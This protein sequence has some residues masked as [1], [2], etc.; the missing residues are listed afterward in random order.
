LLEHGYGNSDSSGAILKTFFIGLNSSGA[1]A[2]QP[3]THWLASAMRV[4]QPLSTSI[5]FRFGIH[6]TSTWWRKT[7]HGV[8]AP[9]NRPSRTS[10]TP[11]TKVCSTAFVDWRRRLFAI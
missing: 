9:P 4:Q 11:R 8:A 3:V 6:T 10:S 5:Y 2:R 1:R 7:H